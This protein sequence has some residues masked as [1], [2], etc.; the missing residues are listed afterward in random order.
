MAL[1][2]VIAIG[3]VERLPEDIGNLITMED[4]CPFRP[5]MVTCAVFKQ[6]QVDLKIV[7]DQGFLRKFSNIRAFHLSF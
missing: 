7:I 6:V 1:G 5:R 3:I 4:A 2:L